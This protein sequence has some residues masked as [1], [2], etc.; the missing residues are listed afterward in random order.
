ME[1]AEGEQEAAALLSL[2]DNEPTFRDALHHCE[3]VFKDH[4][5]ESLLEVMYPA[6]A[7]DAADSRLNLTKY[8]QPAIFALEWCLALAFDCP[9][10][11]L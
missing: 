8:S 5:G 3:V 9:W 4:T 7:S 6:T 11:F 10:C 2:Y 1:D